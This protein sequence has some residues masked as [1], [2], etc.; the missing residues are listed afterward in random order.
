MT[1]FRKCCAFIQKDLISETSYKFSFFLQFFGIFVST[2]V[3]FFLSKL[4]EGRDIPYLKPYGG[5]YFAFVLIGIAF[6]NYLTVAIR[7]LA[8]SIRQAQMMGTLEAL[9]VT[10]T[11]IPTIILGSSLYK[12]I[13][14]SIQVI[15]YLMLGTIVFGV[16]FSQANYFGA[17]LILILTVTSFNCIGIIS[18]SFIMIFKKGDPITWLFT[19]ISWLLG[20]VYYPIQVLPDWLEKLSYFLPITYSLEGMRLALLQGYELKTLLPNIFAL[21]IFSVLLLPLSLLIFKYAVKKTK[22]NGSLAQY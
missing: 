15:V 1:F 22:I 19:S 4:F 16:N 17:L 11:E 13:F 3:F 20:G 14:T 18:A 12:Y 8:Q 7:G 6:S 21:L 9:L 2:L 5:N 10:Q